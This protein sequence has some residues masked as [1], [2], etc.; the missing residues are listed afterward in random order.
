M[1]PS[2][3]LHILGPDDTTLH[4]AYCDYV[5]HVFR[6]ADFHRWCSW[7]QWNDDYRAFALVDHGIVVANASVMRMRLLLDGVETEGFQLGAVGCLPS[8]RGRGLA[9]QVLQAALAHCGNKPVLLFANENVRDFYPRFGFRAASQSLFEIDH[10]AAPADARAP[11]LDL[12]DAALRR[13]FLRVADAAPPSS[14][15]FAARGYGRVATW[16]VANRFASEL[17]RLDDDTWVFAQVEDGVLLIEDVF[18]LQRFDLQAAV[19]RLIDAPI[20]TIRF[21][22]TPD[23]L[24]PQARLA[25]I[26]DDAE[27][28][29]RDCDLPIGATRFP[30]LA[31]T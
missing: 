27:L 28:F 4:A 6:K 16:Y 23:R 2:L 3:P 26:D 9:R 14:H 7:G 8:L 19:P 31:R 22:M 21:G 17:R 24:C 20:H 10:T 11:V 18:A 29:L 12:A 30:L 5:A 25:G 1:T 13:E 15:R